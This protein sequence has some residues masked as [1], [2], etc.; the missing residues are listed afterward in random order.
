R[1]RSE[2]AEI[3]R[4]RLDMLNSHRAVMLDD[5][6]APASVKAVDVYEDVFA[7]DN[8]CAEVWLHGRLNAGNYRFEAV[9][10]R[11][12]FECVVKLGAG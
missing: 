10:I 1:P 9:D 5:D 2:R 3:V 12:Q 7:V 11:F 6:G 4:I 8:H